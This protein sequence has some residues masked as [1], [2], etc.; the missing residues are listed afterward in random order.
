VDLEV[1][2]SSRGGG[3]MNFNDLLSN[4][5]RSGRHKKN[6]SRWHP[7][8]ERRAMGTLTAFIA[9]SEPS[10]VIF[11]PLRPGLDMVV[12][13]AAGVVGLTSAAFTPGDCSSEISVCRAS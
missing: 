7:A 9:Q 1:P 6:D 10:K 11:R 4:P 5:V 2:R 13:G 12:G 3:T 8:D